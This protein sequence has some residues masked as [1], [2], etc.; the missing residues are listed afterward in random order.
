MHYSVV[1]L[2]FLSLAFRWWLASAVIFDSSFDIKKNPTQASFSFWT[3]P[4]TP[5][6]S[7]LHLGPVF[8]SPSAPCSSWINH[9]RIF[10][11]SSLILSRLDTGLLGTAN[12]C[13]ALGIKFAVWKF[14]QHSLT[15]LFSYKAGTP[16]TFAEWM[17]EFIFDAQPKN[18]LV[19]REHPYIF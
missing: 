13:S 15:N 2:R 9:K 19:G 6:N 7:F 16:E 18:S 12:V 3:G 5:D 10:Q 11:Q 1:Y 14:I 4:I 8:P 17:N